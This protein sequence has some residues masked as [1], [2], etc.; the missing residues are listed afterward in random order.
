M[1]V[2]PYAPPFVFDIT[3][4]TGLS[5]D[6]MFVAVPICSYAI[7]TATAK[8]CPIPLAAKHVIELSLVQPESSQA[9][10]SYF[11]EDE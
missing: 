11:S 9:V 3:L 1:T 4:R 8:E 10:C 5:N 7:L 2:P 6:I